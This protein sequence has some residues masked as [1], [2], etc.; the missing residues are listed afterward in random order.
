[1][2]VNVFCFWALKIPLAYALAKWLGLGPIGVFVAISVAYSV[3]ALIGGA[4]FRSGRWK[5]AR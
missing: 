5:L 1:M 3:Q 2:L 4:L